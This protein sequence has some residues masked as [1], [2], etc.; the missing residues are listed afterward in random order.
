MEVGCESVLEFDGREVLHLAP[1]DAAQVLPEP[2]HQ[3]GKQ[4]RR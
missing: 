1:A 3:P 2:V 4:D